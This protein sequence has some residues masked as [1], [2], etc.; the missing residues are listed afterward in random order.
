MPFY[1]LLLI[2][3]IGNF[4]TA[5]Q[6]KRLMCSLVLTHL[7]YFNAVLINSSDAI[8]KQFQIVQNFV[9]KTLMKKRKQYST[10]EL[11]G[12]PLTSRKIQ[13]YL[14]A[15]NSSYNSLKKKGPP[16]FKQN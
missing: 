5:D 7:D 16:I 3:K 13:M 4:L 12:T 6:L 2:H 15:S 11:Q 8:T 10:T 1:S 14:Q 9:A